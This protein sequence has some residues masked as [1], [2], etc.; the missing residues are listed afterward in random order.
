MEINGIYL[1]VLD[2]FVHLDIKVPI[3]VLALKILQRVLHF[4]FSLFLL[5]CQIFA[6][7]LHLIAWA[8][9]LLA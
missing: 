4:L 9:S 2:V 8:V 3:L 5:N 6:H 1:L 7:N